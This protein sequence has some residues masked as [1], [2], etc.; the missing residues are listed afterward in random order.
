ME[1]FVGVLLIFIALIEIVWITI[2]VN[3]NIRA[4]R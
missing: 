1:V 2:S 3:G 4:G